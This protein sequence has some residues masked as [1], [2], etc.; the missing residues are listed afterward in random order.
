[1]YQKMLVRV[2]Q[3]VNEKCKAINLIIIIYT[4]SEI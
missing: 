4:T 2:H 3:W 1:M